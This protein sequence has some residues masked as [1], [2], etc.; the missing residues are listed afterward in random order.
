MKITSYEDINFLLQDF[1]KSVQSVLKENIV[2]IYL[3]GSLS[4]G[5]FIPERS[6]IDLTVVVKE[7]ISQ[8]KLKQIEQLHLELEQ[9]H[10]KWT[11]RVE[12]QYVPL[13]MF[14]HILPVELRRPYYG[15]G[16]FHPEALYGNEWLINNYFLYKHGISLVGLE[17][18][19]LIKPIDTKEVQKASA[20]DLFREW[21]P[22]IGN[23]TFFKNSHFQS[24]V[25][26]N[27][28]RILY[29]VICS[30]FASKVVSA[31]WVKKEYPQ[32]KNLIEKAE[33]WKHGDE[34]NM[35]NEVEEFIKFAVNKVNEK[36]LI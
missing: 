20:R 16:K 22:K 1:V 12:C 7:P 13:E 17:F 6:D 18:K 4:Y 25:V 36:Q 11:K 8:E 3:M 26:L 2:G 21:V 15:A 14:K 30:D 5:D 27:V 34:M 9:K 23:S 24:Y 29:T 35:Q 32:W 19:E 33:K 31:E 10:I 28:C